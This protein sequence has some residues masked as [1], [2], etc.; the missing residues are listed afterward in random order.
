MGGSCPIRP[1]TLGS[2][3]FSYFASVSK[4]VAFVVNIPTGPV[5]KQAEPCAASPWVASRVCSS[6]L[7][8]DKG[9]RAH[10][11]YSWCLW[12]G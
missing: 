8:L 10:S 11:C 2:Y 3:S 1:F 7:C 9:G 4:P 6:F 5:K 12:T